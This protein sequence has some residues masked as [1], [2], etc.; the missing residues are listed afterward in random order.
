MQLPTLLA[1]R[2]EEKVQWCV[3]VSASFAS[4]AGE[5][6]SAEPGEQAASSCFEDECLSCMAAEADSKLHSQ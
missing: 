5:G 4:V 1:Q 3:C 2:L 6:P